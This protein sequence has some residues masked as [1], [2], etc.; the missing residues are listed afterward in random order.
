M[1]AHACMHVCERKLRRTCCPVC[2]VAQVE[3]VTAGM[4]AEWGARL[5]DTRRWALAALAVVLLLALLA[6]GGTW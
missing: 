4:V 5:A 6:V 2:P 3:K 1:C